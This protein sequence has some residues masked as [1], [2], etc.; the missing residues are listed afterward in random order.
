[1]N[2][3]VPSPVGSA[4]AAVLRCAA[5]TARLLARRQI[6]LPAR[7][8]GLRLGF[9]DGTSA[10]VY[11]E[12]VVDRGPV[13]DPCVFV[14][15]FRLRTRSG[16]G[17]SG[18]PY[19]QEVVLADLDLRGDLEPGVALN[20]VRAPT[21][22]IV[23]EEDDLALE[24]NRQAQL[25]LRCPSQLAVVPGAG[26]LFE[27]PG[28]LRAAATLAAQWF[29]YYLA[30]RLR[31]A[32]GPDSGMS[33][34]RAFSRLPGASVPVVHP[35]RGRTATRGRRRASAPGTGEIRRGGRPR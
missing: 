31:T 13:V 6:H 20:E 32:P 35:D 8:V 18:R 24:L 25:H 7:Y 28:T 1:M 21:L 17:W 22:L 29:G 3:Q 30:G 4:M 27:E 23:G 14:V 10:R 34:L 12:T 5:V 11:R 33:G 26:H 19:R 9:A 2:E 15:E 16:T